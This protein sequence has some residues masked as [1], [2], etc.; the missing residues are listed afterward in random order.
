MHNHRRVSTFTSAVLAALLL[1][2]LSGCAAGSETAG[3]QATLVPTSAPPVETDP[4]PTSTAAPTDLPNTDTAVLPAQ[5]VTP[6]TV[7]LP[8]ILT[9]T[10]PP[11]FPPAGSLRWTQ[12]IGG[13]NRPV[14]FVDPADGTGR[15][16]IL[17]QEGLI[18]TIQNGELLSEPFMD[19]RDRVGAS[20]SEQGLLGMD[21]EPGFA[22]NGRFYL[23]YTDRNGD[24]VIARY[25]VR[26]DD[27]QFGD[28][29]S[30][31]VL[32]RVD[33]PYANHNGG[34]VVFGPDGY[35]YLS[36]GDGGSGGD[37]QGNG[38]NP[39][40]LLGT[41]LRIDV[42]GDGAYSIP[43]DN[44]FADGANGRQEVWAWGLR[45]PWRFSFD[46]V[47]G[48]LFIADVGQSAWEEINFYP[49]GSPPGPNFGWNYYEGN[50]A[51][52]GSPPAGLDLVFPVWVYGRDLGCSV[53]GGYVYRGTEIPALNGVYV[54][55]D[56][57]N[58]NTM[59]LLQNESGEWQAQVLVQFSARVSAFGQDAAGE[60]YV[61]DHS[62]GAL[63]KLV[64]Q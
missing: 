26:T 25:T 43:P 51:Y 24:T 42:R 64:S 21:V 14:G 40:T 45:N 55:S 20:A 33:Q 60:L 10:S 34:G 8:V 30:E 5:T 36:L 52:A 63:Y 13:L 12:I 62:G 54:Y 53:T 49:A 16:F 22:E 41:L 56:Y 31:Q 19:L 23:N 17:E 11:S 32:L 6:T 35:L 2:L 28:P 38:Q 18:R 44:P 3:P 46:R 48:D 4:P 37:P 61:L 29:A 15:F 59:G 1:T 57:C 7:F 27:P 58:G 47:T 50:A 9:P 39:H